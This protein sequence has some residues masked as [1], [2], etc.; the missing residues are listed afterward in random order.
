MRRDLEQPYPNGPNGEVYLPVA[1][2][3]RREPR[4]NPVPESHDAIS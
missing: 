1:G 4:G 2:L 3:E